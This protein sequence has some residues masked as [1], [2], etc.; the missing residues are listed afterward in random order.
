MKF[1][2][3]ENLPVEVAGLLRR[4]GHEATT[5]LEQHLGG[6]ADPVIASTCRREGL[7]LITLD[8]DFGDIRVYPPEQFSGLVILRLRRQDK[9][10]VLEVFTRL[11]GAFSREPLEGRLWIVEE[12]RIRIRG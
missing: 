12:E 6:G 1:K 5:V 2:I 4:A 7:I 10:Q 3:D 11:V 8:T 9:A